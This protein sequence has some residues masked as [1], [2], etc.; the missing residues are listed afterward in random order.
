MPATDGDPCLENALTGMKTRKVMDYW[1]AR[2]GAAPAPDWPSFKLMDLYQ[3]APIM[4]VLDKLP[5]VDVIDYRYRFVG[6]QIVQ[7]RWKLPV[8]DHTGLTYFEARHQYDFKEVKDAY[9]R[10]ATECRPGVMLRNFDA[11]DA[12]GTHERLI[13]PLIG[14]D[15]AVDKLVVVVE[16]INE[17]IK[18]RRNEGTSL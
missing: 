12:S 7:Y 15:G 10:S 17:V 5:G 14:G 6:T 11:F 8:P 13:L 1:K 3:E 4:L 16:R 9:D 18:Q 2:A